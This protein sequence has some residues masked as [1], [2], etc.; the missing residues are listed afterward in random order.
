MATK[1][2]V[3]TQINGESVEFLCEDRES[4][5]EVLRDSL[6][7]T[8]S[9]EGCNNGNCGSC[10]VLMNGAPVLSCLVL[11]A[12]AEGREIET[13]EGIANSGNLVELQQ[14]FLEDAALQCGVCTPGFLVSAQALLVQN[15]RP[16]ED[17]I[18]FKLSG[19]LCRCTGYDK[20][21]KAVQHAS[22]RMAADRS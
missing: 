19:N 7:M 15:P 20:I 10:T 16:T 17:E 8:G 6:N 18:R 11:A 14:C 4:L 2:H 13:V 3:V 21:I 12:E 1:R 22:E 9:K 5:L